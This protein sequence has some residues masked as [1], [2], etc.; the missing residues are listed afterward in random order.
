MKDAT[1]HVVQPTEERLYNQ[2]MNRRNVNTLEI[3]DTWVDRDRETFIT[4]TQ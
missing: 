3:H 1:P 4:S 2:E